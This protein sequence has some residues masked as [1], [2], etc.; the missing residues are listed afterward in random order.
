MKCTGMGTNDRAIHHPIFHSEILGKMDQHP[1]PDI[2]F[3]PTLETFEN[4]VPF[5]IFFR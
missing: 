1:F 3:A 5:A 4:T 2:I